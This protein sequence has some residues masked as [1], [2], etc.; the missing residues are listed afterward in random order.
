M[1][2]TREIPRSPLEILAAYLP[3]SLSPAAP[4]FFLVA[5]RNKATV[6]WRHDGWSLLLFA[7]VSNT[8]RCWVR[9]WYINGE[10]VEL[11]L[12]ANTLSYCLMPVLPVVEYLHVVVARKDWQESTW[13]LRENGRL[14]RS[15]CKMWRSKVISGIVA[16]IILSF[17]QSLSTMIDLSAVVRL[18]WGTQGVTGVCSGEGDAL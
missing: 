6:V 3:Q 18:S 12:Y 7:P 8:E 17:S 13:S 15:F 11:L 9:R 2:S 1:P 14:W 16:S 5:F 10:V 4:L